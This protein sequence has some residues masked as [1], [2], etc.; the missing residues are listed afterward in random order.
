MTARSAFCVMSCR[1]CSICISVC[2][3]AHHVSPMLQLLG[4]CHLEK[5]RF[6]EIGVPPNHLLKWEFPLYT[7]QLWGFP[8]ETSKCSS[9]APQSQAVLDY[10]SGS[11]VLAICAAHLGA[12]TVVGVDVD[13]GSVDTCQ[14]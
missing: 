6:P 5:W 11:G 14:G 8:M 10:G 13:E 2:V 12:S 7:I 4:S 3:C 9:K 1:V